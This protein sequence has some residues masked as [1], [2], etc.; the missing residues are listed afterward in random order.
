MER[1]TD[2]EHTALVQ[3]I[4]KRE[5]TAAQLAMWYGLTVQELR[6]FVDAHW[7]ELHA[8]RAALEAAPDESTDDDETPRDVVTPEH[9]DALWISSKLERLTRYQNIADRL[10]QNVMNGHS[11]GSE[12]ATDLRELRSY[13]LAAANEL[14]QLLH[15]GSGDSGT[16][17]T[18]GIEITGIDLETLR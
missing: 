2:E 9:L 5:G 11:V 7:R 1:L 16:S 10:Y 15:R 13:M 8:A 12:Y 14:G 18:L 4:V 6:A 17:D 3:A